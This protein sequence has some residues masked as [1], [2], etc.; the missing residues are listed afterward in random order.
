M[1]GRSA[2]GSRK[3]EWIM[4]RAHARTNRFCPPVVRPAARALLLSL[5]LSCIG[6]GAARTDSNAVTGVWQGTIR[7]SDP[8]YRI[9]LHVNSETNGTRTV[10]VD[11]PD[12]GKLGVPVQSIEINTG[13]AGNV[14]WSFSE[15]GK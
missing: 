1:R 5:S 10:I 8:D 4:N 7:L 9:V 12:T 13:M 15:D 11:S 6:F 3:G 14:L 2:T